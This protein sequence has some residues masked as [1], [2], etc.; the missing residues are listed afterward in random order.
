VKV[1]DDIATLLG[2]LDGARV[3]EIGGGYGGQCR[4]LDALFRLDSY[5]L[6]DLRPALQL[7]DRFLNHFSLRC[8]MSFACVNELACDSYDLVISNYAFSELTR[9]TQETYFRK[10]IANSRRGYMTYND[11]NPPEWHS[12]TRDDIQAR[13]KGVVLPEFPLTHPRNCIIVWGAQDHAGVDDRPPAPGP[14][15]VVDAEV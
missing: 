11:I 6:V 10:V 4:I 2:R 5:V 1:A 15:W 9:D 14:W 3:C 8:K 13:V 12:M 7:A